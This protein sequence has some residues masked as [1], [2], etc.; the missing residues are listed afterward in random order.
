VRFAIRLLVPLTAVALVACG[1]GDDAP[2]PLAQR[3]PTAADAPGTKPD[4]VEKGETAGDL[5]EFIVS[6]SQALIDPDEGELTTVFQE[7]G[8]KRAGLDVR[9]Y[10][11]THS[12]TAPHLF[13]WFIELD[14]ED[15]AR[16][17]LDWVEADSMKP[18]PRSCAV[19][20]SSF[21]VDGIPDARGVHRIA[22]AEDIEAAGTEDQQPSDDYWVGFTVGTV[23]YTVALQGPPG[24]VSEEQAQGIASAYYDRLT[25]D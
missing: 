12:P 11:D 18:C 22:T 8:F 16:S 25:G 21:D 17:A 19:R 1:G 6:F 7:A 15:G 14:S 5:D 9:F 13:S 24:S 4:P 2:V 10:G 3:F 23:V 20:V